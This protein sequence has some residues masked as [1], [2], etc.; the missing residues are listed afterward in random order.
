M[1]VYKN[2]WVLRATRNAQVTSLSPRGVSPLFPFLFHA[3]LH[4]FPSILLHN[5]YISIHIKFWCPQSHASPFSPN[6]DHLSHHC[7]AFFPLFFFFMFNLSFH[8][9]HLTITIFL[10][11]ISPILLPSHLYIIFSMKTEIQTFKQKVLLF[12]FWNLYCN[13]WHLLLI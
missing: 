1:Q 5:K 3:S 8:I 13:N 9:I 6:H 11:S 2:L 4:L 7:Y 10:P 12:L